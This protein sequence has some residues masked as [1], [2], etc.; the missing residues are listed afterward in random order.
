MM[1]LETKVHEVDVNT[2]GRDEMAI[3]DSILELERFAKRM[4][5]GV[6]HTGFFRSM[7]DPLPHVKDDKENV[8]VRAEMWFSKEALFALKRQS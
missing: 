7:F 4:G 5:G 1:K 2:L 6:V 8:Y 3:V